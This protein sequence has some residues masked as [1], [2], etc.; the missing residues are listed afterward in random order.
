MPGSDY[1]K[2]ETIKTPVSCG[3]FNVR[4]GG[5]YGNVLDVSPFMFGAF[6]EA[7]RTD[8]LSTQGVTNNPTNLKFI[9]VDIMK[10]GNYLSEEEHDVLIFN[11][12][13][14]DPSK[15]P[16]EGKVLN[17]DTLFELFGERLGFKLDAGID[18]SFDNIYATTVLLNYMDWI[19]SFGINPDMGLFYLPV[20]TFNGLA[21]LTFNA[22]TTPGLWLHVK[23]LG[24]EL[25]QID[26]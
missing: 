20:W 7:Q 22:P 4:G 26:D 8:E 21:K 16:A 12:F 19:Y 5:V 6:I 24:N 1:L 11:N 9:N 25:I 2:I 14:A 3:G 13:R 17:V 23:A 10:A 18:N 15:A